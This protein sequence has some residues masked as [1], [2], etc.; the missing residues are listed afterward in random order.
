MTTPSCFPSPRVPSSRTNHRLRLTVTIHP[1]PGTIL[2][3][4][5]SDGFRPPEMVKRRPAIVLSHPIPGRQLLCT[6]VPLSTTA[7]R[8]VLPHHLQITLDPPLPAPYPA[9]TMWVKGDIVLTV[10]FRRLR[11]LFAGNERAAKQQRRA[12]SA[13]IQRFDLGVV[14]PGLVR[15]SRRES[16]PIGL[17]QPGRIAPFALMKSRKVTDDRVKVTERLPRRGALVWPS[18]PPLPM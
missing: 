15:K 1:V 14:R 10:A 8:P 2:R 9:P 17:F 16:L 6:T 4:D 12:V 7:P 13:T 18:A 3:V 5:L 11:L